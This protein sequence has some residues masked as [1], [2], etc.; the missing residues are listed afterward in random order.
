MNIKWYTVSQKLLIFLSGQRSVINVALSFNF[1][2]Y[3]NSTISKML[4]KIK[5]WDIAKIKNDNSTISIWCTYV[6]V[7]TYITWK[8]TDGVLY[9]SRH[10]TDTPTHVNFYWK[11]NATPKAQ[12]TRECKYCTNCVCCVSAILYLFPTSSPSFFFELAKFF[13]YFL[14]F[15]FFAPPLSLTLLNSVFCVF[16]NTLFYLFCLTLPQCHNLISTS[17]PNHHLFS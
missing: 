2:L 8:R 1:K 13:C 14:F 9:T 11:I 6:Q 4:T 16:W 10:T 3:F 12:R 17:F 15:L 5:Q 7:V